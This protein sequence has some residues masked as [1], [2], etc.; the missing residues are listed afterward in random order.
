MPIFYWF[1]T[2]LACSLSMKRLRLLVGCLAGVASVAQA[3]LPDDRTVALVRTDLTAGK[4][5]ALSE[6]FG[7]DVK[8]VLDG[9]AAHY[10]KDQA[11]MVFQDYLRHHPMGPAVVYRQASPSPE[12]RY[13]QARC[14]AN[15]QMPMRVDVVLQEIN[16]RFVVNTFQ[17]TPER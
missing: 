4:A 6:F 11:Q 14:A 13:I 1:G 9:E 10:S 2:R 7:E 16:G 5:L 3:Q 8:L 12:L 15:P 17:L